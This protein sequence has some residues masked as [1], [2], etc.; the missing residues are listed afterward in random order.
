MNVIRSALLVVSL[1]W[2]VRGCAIES[3]CAF[4]GQPDRDQ[5]PHRGENSL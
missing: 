2:W 4:A 5:N 3:R 1:L